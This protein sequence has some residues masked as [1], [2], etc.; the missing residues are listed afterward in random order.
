MNDETFSQANPMP[1]LDDIQGHLTAGNLAKAEAVLKELPAELALSDRAKLFESRLR[2]EQGDSDQATAIVNE[3]LVHRADKNPWVWLQ[4]IT[5]FVAN[6][7]IDLARTVFMDG[8][9]TALEQNEQVGLAGLDAVLGKT[10]GQQGKVAILT[11]ALERAPDARAFQLRLATRHALGGQPQ[12]ALDLLN[13]A[14]KTG[15]LPPHAERTKT[16]LYPFVSGY[17]DALDRLK[18]EME[19]NSA[20]SVQLR[21]MARYATACHRHD[22]AFAALND[23]L[24]RFP[25]DWLVLYRLV[26]SKLSDTER[27]NVLERLYALQSKIKPEPAWLL[28]LGILAL[29]AGDRKKADQ[30]LSAVD[31]KS[32]V[33]WTAKV[34]CGALAAAGS[35]GPADVDLRD[36]A[37]ITEVPRSGAVGTVI[38]FANMTGGLEVLPLSYVDGLLSS[39]PL[40]VIYLR[41]FSGLMF[42]QGVRSC[43]SGVSMLHE[44]LN[45]LVAKHGGPVLTIGN[46]FG[47]SAAVRA[48]LAIDGAQSLSFAGVL[49]LVDGLEDGN[50]MV[51]QGAWEMKNA[52]PLVDIYTELRKRPDLQVTHVFGADFDPDIKRSKK[53]EG[54]QNCTLQPIEGV[55]H[56]YAG[57]ESI[58]HRQFVPLIRSLFGI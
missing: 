37:E 12:K 51:S 9:A 20:P 7:E 18:A 52:G 6:D 10:P 3:H 43:G 55:G 5:V 11:E 21:R 16:M 49:D 45:E 33:G 57:M 39:L 50:S 8:V 1:N 31:S 19:T 40:N 29:Q 30:I 25:E 4:C 32:T 56:H 38:F 58:A 28:Q 48:A 2:L 26:R 27:R 46:S 13:E 35:V 24:E 42:Q 54:L 23:A 47:A 41:D 36:N 34:L 22:E 53:I 17:S 15:P 14:E 44:H